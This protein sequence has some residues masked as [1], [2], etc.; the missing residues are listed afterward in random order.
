M[1]VYCD[2]TR[3]DGTWT[4]GALLWRQRSEAFRCIGRHQQ[5]RHRGHQQLQ[6]MSHHRDHSARSAV[7]VSLPDSRSPIVSRYAANKHWA[8]KT[9]CA[10]YFDVAAGRE[11][12]RWVGWTGVAAKT[13]ANR[14]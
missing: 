6:S 5:R 1:I 4:C 2:V 9:R 13:I 10:G 3:N 7:P 11:A 12:P 8:V 14:F